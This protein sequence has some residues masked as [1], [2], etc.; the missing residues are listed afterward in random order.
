MNPE[1]HYQLTETLNTLQKLLKEMEVDKSCLTCI[2]FDNYSRGCKV[3][4]NITPP[5]HIIHNGCPQWAFDSI[6]F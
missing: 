5:E 1:F 6:P 3:A 4:N 2:N